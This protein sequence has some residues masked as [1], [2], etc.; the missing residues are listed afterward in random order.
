MDFAHY[1]NAWRAHE[2][3]SHLA[4]AARTKV[5]FS[6]ALNYA[7]GSSAPPRTKIPRLALIIG[8]APGDLW[9]AAERTR[10]RLKKANERAARDAIGSLKQGQKILNVNKHA[11][12]AATLTRGRP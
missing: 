10:N 3:L 8:V 2:G 7:T 5:C 9:D 4:A 1:W 12:H 6:S 11:R